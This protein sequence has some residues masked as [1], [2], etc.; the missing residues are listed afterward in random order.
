MMTPLELAEIVDGEADYWRA[1]DAPVEADD[2]H[3]YEPDHDYAYDAMMDAA[4]EAGVLED[5]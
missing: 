2:D 5:C 4:L 3:W 1:A